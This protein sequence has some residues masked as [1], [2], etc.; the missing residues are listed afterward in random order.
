M[1]K[2]ERFIKRITYSA[3]ILCLPLPTS[4]SLRNVKDLLLKDL[5]SEKSLIFFSFEQRIKTAVHVN[6]QSAGKQQLS[7][8]PFRQTERLNHITELHTCLVRIQMCTND[9]DW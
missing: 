7:P 3:A 5:L 8:H 1:I 2:S 9:D 6:T 4:E